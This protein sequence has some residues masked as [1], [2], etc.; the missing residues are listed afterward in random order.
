MGEWSFEFEGQNLS[1]IGKLGDFVVEVAKAGD[2]ERA[3][4]FMDAYTAAELVV[5]DG[6]EAEAR[7]IAAQNVGYVAGYYGQED[8]QAVWDVF[9]VSHPVFG[10]TSPTP[11]VAVE[12]GKRSAY[13]TGTDA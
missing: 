1:T 6:D 2:R 3:K 8:M 7:S 5:T 4:R 9:D 11:E 13:S 12:A 10:R